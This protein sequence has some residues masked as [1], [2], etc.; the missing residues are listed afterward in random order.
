MFKFLCKLK[1]SKLILLIYRKVF[2]ILS[3]L[4][5]N[6]QLIIFESFSGRQYSDNPRAIYE[7]LYDKD[8][9]YKMV[10]SVDKNYIHNFKG[11]KLN[12]IQRYS[13]IWLIYMCRAKY[14]VSNSRLPLWFYKSS[15]TIYLQTW[16]GTPLKKLAFDMREVHIPTHK[17]NQYK[18]DFA[19]EAMRWNY[20]I[21]PNKYSTDIFKRAFKF[22]NKILETGYPRNDFLIK[23]NNES[24]ITNI[25]KEARLPLN[26]K[27][28]LYA[29]TWRDNE[30][31]HGKFTFDLKL[32]LLKMKASLGNDYIILLR[33]HYNISQHIDLSEFQ[34]FAYNFSSYEDIRSLYIISDLLITDYS[35]VFFDY[36]ILRKPILFY[37]YDIEFYR[38]TLRG[39]YFDL[40]KHAPGPLLTTTDEI[41]QS[42]ISIQRSDEF[43]TDEKYQNFINRFC[44]LEDGESTDRV[45]RSIFL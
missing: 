7:Y 12:Y 8:Y 2:M 10:W 6:S 19:R 29:P 5:K 23:K 21:S 18:E 24:T 41:I 31:Q 25:K 32:D 4:P 40:E 44:Y 34:D 36:A 15:K 22:N 17:T 45:V 39:F 14:W 30:Y 38:E 9:N 1:Q 3:F 33:L 20:L 11:E 27:I 13:L 16:H 42:I 28:I 37:V 35:S 26:K 43:I